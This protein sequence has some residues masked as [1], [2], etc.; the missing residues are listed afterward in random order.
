MSEDSTIAA[1]A[2][3]EEDSITAV[4]AALGSIQALLVALQGEGS[5]SAATLAAAAQVQTDL[6]GVASTAQGDLA[7]D[8]APPAAPPAT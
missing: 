7:A 5:L 1:E 6:A 4:L 3:A 8:Q 2:A